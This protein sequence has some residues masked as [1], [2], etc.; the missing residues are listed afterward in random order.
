MMQEE[1]EKLAGYHVKAD[2]YDAI[3]KLYLNCD[4]D[5]TQ[6]V[7]KFGKTFKFFAVKP[8]PHIIRISKGM[9]SKGCK[10][11]QYEVIKID[12]KTG[13]KFVREIPDTLEY[14]Y[15]SKVDA[16]LSEVEEI[17][18]EPERYYVVVW[19]YD[20]TVSKT[21]T[22]FDKGELIFCAAIQH[23]EDCNGEVNYY[24][25]GRPIGYYTRKQEALKI[26]RN[27]E[28][29]HAEVA[30]AEVYKEKVFRA[31]LCA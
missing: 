17:K 6:F 29:S 9:T 27:I 21:P 18:S 12:V 13:K 5:K 26:A 1:F 30:A 25:C 19:L 23:D 2:V 22:V 15:G 20:G 16:E 8:Q 3:E 4:L 24:N 11:S 7:K 28:K 10:I 14:C 31:L